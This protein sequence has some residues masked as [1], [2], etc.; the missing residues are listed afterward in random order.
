MKYVNNIKNLKK[1]KEVI[2]ATDDDREGEGIGWHLCKVL[3]Y[4]KLQNELFFMKL[5]KK[6]IQKH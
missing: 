1:G 6:R 5:L 3:I 2:I 4:Q